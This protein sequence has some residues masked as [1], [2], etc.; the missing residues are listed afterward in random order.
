MTCKQLSEILTQPYAWDHFV[1]YG[2]PQ[3]GGW[4]GV[5]QEVLESLPIPSTDG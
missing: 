1:A 5:D 2:S 3:K 4:R